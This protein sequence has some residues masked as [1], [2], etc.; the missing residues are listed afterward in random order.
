MVRPTGMVVSAFCGAL[1]LLGVSAQEAYAEEVTRDEAKC[2]Q[3]ASLGLAKFVKKKWQCITRCEQ[4][5]YRIDD[6]NVYN[7]D[8]CVPPYFGATLDCITNEAEPMA[9]AQFNAKC[10]KDCPECYAGGDCSLFADAQIPALEGDVDALRDLVFCDDPNELTGAEFK[11]QKIVAV[12][13]RNFGF[14]KM[15]CLQ[16]CQK[17][18]R[19][20]RTTGSCDPLQQVIDDKTARCIQRKLDRTVDKIDKKCGGLPNT[21][22]PECYAS[23]GLTTGA[24]WANLVELDVDAINGVLFCDDPNQILP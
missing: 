19:R 13:L 3:G 15:R 14:T 21:D 17:S 9:T 20:E 11:C 16:S 8:D 10:S 4:K 1:L 18:E 7:P 22:L 24:A 23:A 12:Q 6:P 5:A 2:Q